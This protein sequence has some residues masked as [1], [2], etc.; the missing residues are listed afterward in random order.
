V[1]EIDL[2]VGGLAELPT[3]KLQMVMKKI[4]G[5]QLAQLANSI[6]MALSQR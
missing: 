3:G 4:F 1:N 2:F 6:N 5:V